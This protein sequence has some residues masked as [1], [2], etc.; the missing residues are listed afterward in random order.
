MGPDEVEEFSRQRSNVPG[1]DFG[2]IKNQQNV[3]K[4]LIKKII[5][6]GVLTNPLRLDA[7]LTTA[8]ESL[9][10]DKD[11]NLRSLALAVSGIRPENVKYATVPY[12][13]TM[14][15][16]AGSSVQL[17]M[18]GVAEL[19]TAIREDKADEWLAAHPQPDVAS[20]TR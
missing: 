15:T 9:T 19:C 3:I 20:F 16:G 10:V 5:S 2:R 1:G 13:G 4:G 14:T 11:L 6:G 7:L 12:V 8:A 17:D 18:A